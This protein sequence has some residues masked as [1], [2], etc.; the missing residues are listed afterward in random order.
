[1][2]NESKQTLVEK[3]VT[4]QPGSAKGPTANNAAL[5]EKQPMVDKPA[6]VSPIIE[7]VETETKT[8]HAHQTD[9][10]VEAQLETSKPIGKTSIDTAQSSFEAAKPEA[11]E[12]VADELVMNA[13][14][15]ETEIIQEEKQPM[16][17]KPTS[18]KPSIEAHQTNVIMTHGSKHLEAVNP[19]HLDVKVEQS[20]NE[21]EVLLQAE[22]LAAL[23]PPSS[24]SVIATD[25]IQNE[26]APMSKQHVAE[27]PQHTNAMIAKTLNEAD[28]S[29]QAKKL[30]AVK[31][32]SCKAVVATDQTQNEA[33]PEVEKP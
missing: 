32:L 19:R 16:T 30:I 26:A 14:Q 24:E 9:T 6:T 15:P 2:F 1:M 25:Q 5:V 12:P 7:E 23:K 13:S 27:K 31:P 18:R 28:A 21:A 17:T 10:L 29:L 22:K 8:A 4:R 3:P 33:A 11:R 20:L